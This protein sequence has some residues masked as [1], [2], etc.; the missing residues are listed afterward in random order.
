[1]GIANFANRSQSYYDRLTVYFPN[2]PVNPSQWISYVCRFRKAEAAGCLQLLLQIYL[3][4]GIRVSQ[5]VNTLV[6]QWGNF[7]ETQSIVKG[8]AIE[9]KKIC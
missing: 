6:D 1:M 5:V 4:V 2:I 7:F 3:E 8:M 9:N